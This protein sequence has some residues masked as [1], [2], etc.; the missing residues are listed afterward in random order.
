MLKQDLLKRLGEQRCIRVVYGPAVPEDLREHIEGG[1]ELRCHNAAFERVV[2][3]GSAGRK[4]NFP[5][6]EIAATT[7]TAAKAAAAGLPRALGDAAAALSTYAKD[8][9]G[10]MSMLQLSKPRKPT[11]ADASTRW[12]I[13]NAPEKYL[14][15]WTYNVDDVLAECGVDEAV[16]DLTAYEQ[17]IYQLDQRLNDRGILA[18]I[19][20]IGNVKALIGEYK[21]F[22]ELQMEKATG[23]KPSQR[24]KI[25][26]WIRANGWP[27]LL[28]MQA[29][30]VKTLVKRSDVPA[31]VKHVLL[32]YS[33]Y[34]NK[35]VSKFDTILDMACAD[36]RLRGQFMFHGANTG[37]WSSLGVQLQNL[38][39]GVIDDPE[40]AITAFRSR[41]LEWIKALYPE[42]DFMKVAASTVRGHLIAAPG[43]KFVCLDFAGVESRMNAW[44]WDEEWKLQAFRD[45]D[46]GT[47]PD[48]YK[49]AYARAFQVDHISVT[50]SQRQ[51]GKVMELALGYEGGAGAFFTMVDTYGIN[52]AELTE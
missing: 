13:E 32:I 51:I 48:L 46:A 10:R 8:D 29:E 2:L 9:G 35:A 3:N 34:G 45:F 25:A 40:T 50:K 6:I 20:A 14:D 15:L 4:V 18:D 22:L 52:L 27:N 1:G 16:P 28:D 42:H 43:K 38:Y 33:T 11:K 49:L 24:E 37:R 7:C 36:G 39:R 30:T 31:N 26:E 21:T 19:E 17:Q 12:T 47:G 44:L 41:S 5:R 23:L